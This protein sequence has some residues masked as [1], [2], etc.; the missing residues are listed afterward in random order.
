MAMDPMPGARNTNS[1]P[2][3]DFTDLNKWDVYPQPDFQPRLYVKEGKAGTGFWYDGPNELP[4]DDEAPTWMAKNYGP[5]WLYEEGG[6]YI[7]SL[8]RW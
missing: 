8:H 6:V 2:S 5:K 7:R 3:F 4:K 1:T